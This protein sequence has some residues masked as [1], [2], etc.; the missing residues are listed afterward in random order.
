MTFLLALVLSRLMAIQ[1]REAPA[2]VGAQLKFVDHGIMQLRMALGAFARGPREGRALSAGIR[3]R[4]LAV[5]LECTH[6]QRES[7]H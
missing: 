1:T 5:H 2:S 7:D 3:Y 4:T 6:N